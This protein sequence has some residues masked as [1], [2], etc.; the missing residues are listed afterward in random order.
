MEEIGVWQFLQKA[1][2][3]ASA[4][5]VV[6]AVYRYIDDL[7]F[8]FKPSGIFSFPSHKDNPVSRDTPTHNFCRYFL[9]KQNRGDGNLPRFL[10]PHTWS[11]SCTKNSQT[12]DTTS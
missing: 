9:R 2:A 10:G 1:D 8:N 7:N 4:Y 12:I 5:I 6:R 3:R 11:S